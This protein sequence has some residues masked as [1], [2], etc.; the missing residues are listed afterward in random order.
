[1]GLS[2]SPDGDEAKLAVQAKVAP[3][4]RRKTT[5]IQFRTFEAPEKGTDELVAWSKS[6]NRTSA[7]LETSRKLLSDLGDFLKAREDSK[8]YSRAALGMSVDPL[9]KLVSEN[10]VPQRIVM[11]LDFGRAWGEVSRALDEAKIPVVDLNRAEGFFQ[12]DFRAED[13]KD[14]GWFSWFDDEPEPV[15][16]VDI[17]LET[18][19]DRVL[20]LASKAENY[21]GDD[22]S[23]QLLS[24]LFE[25]LY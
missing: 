3:G 25:Y 8:S 15:H 5:E 11:K 14:S 13:E 19:G 4:V 21:D 22:R 10:E 23:A 1:M 9:V 17:E 6:A 24:R 7:Q 2:D 16:S 18:R 20:V 12:V